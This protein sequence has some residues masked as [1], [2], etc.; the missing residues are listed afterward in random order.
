MELS[1]A[2]VDN[3]R[4][5][6]FRLQEMKD[7]LEGKDIKIETPQEKKRLRD[8]STELPLIVEKPSVLDEFGFRSPKIQSLKARGVTDTLEMAK[9]MPVN[10][11]FKQ[12]V[13]QHQIGVDQ[14]IE[15][16]FG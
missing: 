4:K 9:M 6:D 13:L 12:F 11:Y 5:P 3:G 14:V 2:E 16:A 10:K 1:D 15:K 7:L 8:K